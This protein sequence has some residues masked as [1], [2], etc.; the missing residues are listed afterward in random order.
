M[1]NFDAYVGSDGSGK[2]PRRQLVLRLLLGL[3]GLAVVIVAIV[4]GMHFWG[5][6]TPK[7]AAEK[8]LV[9]AVAGIKQDQVITGDTAIEVD[10]SEPGRVERV[11]YYVD[12]AFAGVTYALPFDFQLKATKFKDGEH[13]VYAKVFDKKGKA[14]ATK[15][16][17]I[18]IEQAP[19]ADDESS[20][21][22][23]E[24]ADSSS[25]QSTGKSA[26]SSSS[27]GSSSSSSNSGG[28]TPEPDTSAPTAPSGLLLSAS[29]GY[30]VHASW[31]ASTDNRG[32]T[33]YRVYRDGAV[34]G[35]VTATQYTDQTVV[36]GNTYTYKVEAYDAASNTSPSS[37]QPSITLA[38]TSIWISADSPSNTDTDPTPLELGVKFKPLANGTVTGV[39][40]YKPAGTTGTHVGNLW[41][42]SGS[43]LATV[44]FSSETASGW[45][46][47]VFSTPVSVTAG[48]TYTVSYTAPNGYYGYSSGYFTTDGITSQYLTAPS[49]GVA[50]GNGVFSTTTGVRPTSTF[51]GNNYWVD[52]VFVP[53]KN[54]GGPTATV[55]DNSVVH[56]GFPG[57]NNTGVPVGKRLPVRDRGIVVYA[58]DATI[59]DVQ[60]DGEVDI[61]A[62][63]VTIKNTRINS[64]VYL[65]RDQPGG[66]NWYVTIEDTTIALGTVQRGAVT[67]GQT[68]V[69]RSNISGGQ[70]SIIC[71]A[72]CQVYDSWLHGQKMPPDQPWHL[73]GFLSNGASNMTLTHNTISCDTPNNTA[74]GGCSGDLNLYGDFEA[75]QNVTIDGNLL[76]ANQD[77]GYCLAAGYNAFKTYGPDANNVHVTN[78]VFE[79][80]PTGFCAGFGAATDFK[81]S[82]VAMPGGVWSGNVYDDGT[83]VDPPN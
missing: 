27:K 82:G 37:T 48:T 46:A 77:A 57:S 12:N 22:E 5:S 78:N 70:T 45:Q 28:S 79:K 11:E 31:S 65:D 59:E 63:D 44:T 69:R 20:D 2:S 9:V 24:Q 14:Y 58:D 76:T 26:S 81:V 18:T 36:P 35:T 80:G 72:D 32:V 23:Q 21:A 56:S 39:R 6:K 19:V 3:A 1:D 83:V 33:G 73:G 8:P 50:G 64:L 17:T 49:T 62:Q 41:D 42:G 40:Y 34:V 16:V 13:T 67:L 25:P 71:A 15:K 51:G 54:A 4:S 66:H 55:E 10:I 38:P 61:R 60:V 43:N 30:T 52:P 7:Q 75:I 47:A 74:G 68:T 53:N 29:D